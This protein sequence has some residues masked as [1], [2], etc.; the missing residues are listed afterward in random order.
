LEAQI[1]HAQKLESLGVLAGGIAH[2][3]N[4]LL[5]GMLGSASLALMDMA[6]E[7]PAFASVEQIETSAQRAAE[8]VNQMLAYSGKGKFVV[9]PLDLSKLVEEMAHLLETV[10]A[11]GVVLKCNLAGNLPPIQGDAVQIRQVVMNLITN[12][13]DAIGDKSGVVSLTTGVMQMDRDYLAGTYVHD[14]LP[15][16][17]YDYVAVSD[18]GIGMDEETQAKIFD[19]FFT[20]KFTGRGLGL[21]A[22]LGIVRGHKGALR[23]YSEPGRGTT[24]KVLFPCIEGP[25]ETS[26]VASNGAE[27][28]R[29]QG[30]ILVVDDDESVRAI[31]KLMLEKFGFTVIT[32]N[33]GREG[34]EVFRQQPGEF[35]AVLLDMTMPHM[36]GEE[37]FGE[38][39][40]IRSDVR[41]VLSSGYS[42]DDISDRFPVKGLSG[43]IQKPYRAAALIE[44]IKEVLAD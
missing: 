11:K 25:T 16:G 15:D 7:S 8:L 26:K 17:Y 34:V 28:W 13:S 23:L 4:N 41:V 35:A 1:Q 43:F 21:A 44:K 14:E 20:T 12:A 22:A 18:T 6:P 37:T 38:M 5:T 42:E 31:A 39:R 27:G 33:D 9:G 30:T 2:D 29:G 19:P 32:A 10:V 40:R 36:N 24:F 3:F